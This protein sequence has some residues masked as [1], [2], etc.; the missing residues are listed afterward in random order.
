MNK[1]FK[2]IAAVLLIC[3]SLCGCSDTSAGLNEIIDVGTQE[4]S[5]FLG[6]NYTV[7][8]EVKSG[9]H[10][11]GLSVSV[12][13][14]DIMIAQYSGRSDRLA[15]PEK[16]VKLDEDCYYFSGD[17][18]E[19]ILVGGSLVSGDELSET[20]RAN[21]TRG[22]L[23]EKLESCGYSAENMLKCYDGEAA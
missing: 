13:S 17:K 9:L 10:H 11:D 6:E 1:L 14:G 23:A 12:F 22:E 3:F 5:N 16:I 19:G 8:Y 4:V 15:V 20:L 21:I 7:K 18:D 2:L